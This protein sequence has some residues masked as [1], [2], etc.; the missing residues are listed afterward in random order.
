LITIDTLRADHLSAYG[1]P[2][3]TS[4][5]LDALAAEGAL[6]E[7]AYSE[8]NTTNPSHATILTGAPMQVHGV[9]NTPQGLEAP[10]LP[11]LAE[12]FQSAGYATA[13]IV[14]AR[15]LNQG[16]S[17]FGRGFGTYLDVEE[18][19]RGAGETVALASEWIEAHAQ[20]PFF[21]W[22]HL[23]DPHTPYAPP[24]PYDTRFPSPPGPRIDVMFGRLS[25]DEFFRTHPM[26]AAEREAL[27]AEFSRN[28]EGTIGYNRMGV[29]PSELAHLT[30]LYDGE[31]AY[32]D[33]SLGD[34]FS[35]LSRLGLDDHT[36]VVVTSDHGEAFGEHGLYAIHRTI[37]E[38]TLR[39][40][41]ILRYPGRIPAGQRLQTP[42]QHLDI[43]PTVL[44]YAGLSPSESLRGESLA[45]LLSDGAA[46]PIR[47]IFA[48]H[49]R[50][51]AG[52]V[53]DGPWKLIVSRPEM[54]AKAIAAGVQKRVLDRIHPDA[55]ELY[56][57]TSDPGETRN[58]ADSQAAITERL[59]RL[60]TERFPP[61]ARTP[62]ARAVDA[63]TSERL[64][65]LGYTD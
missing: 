28:F 36:L 19:Q 7:V 4:P 47:P 32:A 56:D 14:S 44:G 58:L 22:L 64:R 49:T 53:R 57:L 43:A 1:Y 39:I 21:V 12:R 3:R 31:I 63:E 48:E 60:D 27:S 52:M 25:H 24:P 10:G 23:F 20:Q 42:V 37:Y 40:P 17:G 2:R 26:P 8:S 18:T 61:E 35:T 13:A 45:P 9:V 6:F 62:S 15:H 41:L 16:P 65:A 46:P 59:R 29:T 5:N 33:A 38:E 30:A 51:Y 54:K 55:R 11:M 50:L 34:L